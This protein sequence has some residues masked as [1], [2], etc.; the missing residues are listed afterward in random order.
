MGY[1]KSIANEEFHASL[2]EGD[3]QFTKSRLEEVETGSHCCGSGVSV[4]GRCTEC[5]EHCDEVPME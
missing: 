4:T 1:F 3:L 2:D 5:G